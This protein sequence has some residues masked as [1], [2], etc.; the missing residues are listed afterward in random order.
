MVRTTRRSLGIA[1]AALLLTGSTGC[2]PKWT[3]T[4]RLT[5][6]FDDRRALADRP[7]QLVVAGLSSGQA[8][9]VTAE[10]EDQAGIGWRSTAVYLADGRGEVHLEGDAP[11]RG[12]Y[13]HADGMGLFW[14]MLPTNGSANTVFSPP[15]PAAD[16]A[17]ALPVRIT[18]VADD[19]VTGEFTVLRRWTADGVTRTELNP[20]TDHVAGTLYLPPAG[21]PAKSPVLLLG[22]SEGGNSG[23]AA[24]ALLASH[25][26]PAL[27]VAY[28]GLPGLP[29]TLQN[30]PVEYAVGAARL[31]AERTGSRD[32]TVEGNSRGSELALLVAGQLPDLVRRVMVYAPSAEVNAGLPDGAAW[33]LNGAP[34]PVGPIALDRTPASILAVAGERDR[35]WPSPRWALQLGTPTAAAP[36]RQAVLHAGAG[37]AV[38]GI[39]YLPT[40]STVAPVVG[41]PIDLG[42]DAAANQAAHMQAWSNFLAFLDS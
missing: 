40:G 15:P 5:I 16:D 17:A 24:A 42:G 39:P 1:L 29:D 35:L 19:G 28:F 18:A 37:H 11:I 8:V 38:A 23:V 3:G 12:S 13:H 21:T 4:H 6:L 34:V 27:A 14:S 41:S 36:N 30:I 9:T 31:L 7:V 25:G 2:T 10:A 22:G 20:A 26:H 32:I 33:T